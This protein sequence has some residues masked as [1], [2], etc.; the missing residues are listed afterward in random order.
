MVHVLFAPDQNYDCVMCGRGCKTAWQI[1]VAP[2]EAERIEQ[3]PLGLRVINRNGSAFDK[4]EDGYVIHFPNLDDPRCGFLLDDNRCE[5]HAELGIDAKP[6]TC[7]QFPFM[8]T[9]TPDGIFVGASFFCTS[10]RENSGR[11]LQAHEPWLMERMKQGVRATIIDD[12]V[13]LSE[14]QQT[15]WADY[16]AFEQELSRRIGE[17]G[18]D[19]SVQQALVLTALSGLDGAPLAQGWNDFELE[20]PPLGGKVNSALDTCHFGLIKLFLEERT[21]ERLQALDAA[22]DAGQGLAMPEFNWQE[23]WFQLLRFQQQALGERFEDDIDRWVAMQVHRKA[24]IC[25]RPLLNNL[26]ILALV[27]RFVRTYTALLT[28]RAGLDEARREDYYEALST[29]EAQFGSNGLLADKLSPRFNDFLYQL[30]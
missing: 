6:V 19:L 5:I 28:R 7:Q 10:V 8:M 3:H 11:P 18:V 17:Q 26:W 4:S 24:L 25:D 12:E 9:K 21:P 23:S 29:A 27:P 14:E 20:D 1:K 16:R 2:E 13:P 22:F 30:L 15:S